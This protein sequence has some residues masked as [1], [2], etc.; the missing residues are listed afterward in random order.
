MQYVVSKQ[1]TKNGHKKRPYSNA[2]SLSYNWKRKTKTLVFDIFS[3]RNKRRHLVERWN[4][5]GL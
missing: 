4:E 3:V 1:I 2:I 5:Y